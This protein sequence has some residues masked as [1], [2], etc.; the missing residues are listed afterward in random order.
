[1]YYNDLSI[2][3]LIVPLIVSHFDAKYYIHP[4]CI[5]YIVAVS[6]VDRVW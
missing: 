2:A 4:L 5:Q 3:L 6:R 1:M